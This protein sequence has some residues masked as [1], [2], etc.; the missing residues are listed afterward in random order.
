MGVRVRVRDRVGAT[1][2]I[3][4]KDMIMVTAMD[5]VRVRGARH[6]KA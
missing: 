2:T 3:A 4:D 5:K 1:M 6:D